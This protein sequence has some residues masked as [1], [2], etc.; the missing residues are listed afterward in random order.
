M[1]SSKQSKT[2]GYNE[3]EVIKKRLLNNEKQIRKLSS[4]VLKFISYVPTQGQ[5]APFNIN[6]VYNQIL[7]ELGNLEYE[8]VKNDIKLQNIGKDHRYYEKECQSIKTS[9]GST[10]EEIEKLDKELKITTKK[11]NLKLKYNQLSNHV[12][13]L[14]KM[15]DMENEI[16]LRK[17]KF[18][19]I[20][21]S[22]E[23][24]VLELDSKQKK[25]EFV[26]SS[27]KNFLIEE[28]D[29]K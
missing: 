2:Q 9:I 1:S 24:K 26:L 22:H 18:D 3:E 11:K 5:T 12:V 28:E 21:Q 20:S 8:M 23:E 16:C 15:E 7:E 29:C 10:N 19:E 4:L 13:N 25:L 27:L 14:D 17:R 6:D